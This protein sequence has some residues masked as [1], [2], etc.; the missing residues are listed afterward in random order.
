MFGRINKLFEKKNK[1]TKNHPILKQDAKSERERE[2]GE[3]ERKTKP[4]HDEKCI[5]RGSFQWLL[6]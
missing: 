2:C 3:R 4:V 1:Q 5:E 6:F